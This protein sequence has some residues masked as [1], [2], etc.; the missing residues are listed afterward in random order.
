MNLTLDYTISSTDSSTVDS[1]SLTGRG[2][3]VNLSSTYL[4]YDDSNPQKNLD[5][6]SGAYKARRPNNF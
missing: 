6:L 3:L 4:K 5:L 2:G 1:V